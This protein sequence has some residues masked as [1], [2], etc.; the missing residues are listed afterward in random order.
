MNTKIVG[1]IAA[2]VILLLAGGAYFLSQNKT[3]TNTNVSPT[4]TAATNKTS[5][6]LDLLSSGKNQQ[7]TFKTVTSKSST[8]GAFYIAGNKIRG[9]IKTTVDGK[10]QEINLIRDGEINYMWGSS[11]GNNTGIKMK[12]SLEEVSKNQQTSGFID[13]NNKLDYNCMPWTTDASLF[14]PPTNIKFTDMTSLLAPKTTGTQTKTDTTNPCSQIADI[15]AKTA[16]EN[17]LK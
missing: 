6:L 1:I 4:P 3:T 14:I 13:P 5:S 10:V 9:D 7:C 17:A 12:I 2:A 15:N 16:C 11:L 8:E